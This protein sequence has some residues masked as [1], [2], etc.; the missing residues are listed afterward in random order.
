VPLYSLKLTLAHVGLPLDRVLADLLSQALGR[1]VGRGLAR[2]LLE[3]AQAGLLVHVE[4]SLEEVAPPASQPAFDPATR[5]LYRDEHWLAIDK[6]A[7]LLVHPGADKSLPD[8]VSAVGAWLGDKSWTLHHRL[9]R[10]TSGLVLLSLS[11]AARLSVAAQFEKRQVEK[12]YLCRVA[13]FGG[14]ASW[15]CDLPLSERRGRVAVDASHPQTKAAYTEFRRVR[16]DEGLVE[17]RPKTGRKHQIRVHLAWQGRPI[18]GDTLYG[19]PAAPRLM[20][21]AHRL[22]LLHPTG[23]LRTLEA[24]PPA[25]FRGA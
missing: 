18:V 23:S 19:G 9:D 25:E 3:R 20:L 12:V 24:P 10:E 22:I 2:K 21:H 11:D 1:A 5:V 7:G 17:A 4:L 15:V 6:P 8:M 16:P 13:P 14:P